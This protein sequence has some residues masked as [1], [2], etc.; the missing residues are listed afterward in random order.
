MCA[1]P[2]NDYV[3][4]TVR[5]ELHARLKRLSVSLGLGKYG[6]QKLLER[7]L[8]HAEQNP[9]LFEKRV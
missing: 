6:Q 9:A 7:M 5:K 3:L 8:D 1:M 2:R 4:F